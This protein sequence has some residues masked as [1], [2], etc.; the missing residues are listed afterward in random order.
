MEKKSRHHSGTYWAAKGWPP[1]FTTWM[2]L[3]GDPLVA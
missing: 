1:S 2:A 3:A